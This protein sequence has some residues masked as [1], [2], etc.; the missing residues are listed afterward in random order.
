MEKQ[1]LLTALEKVKPGLANKEM[2]EQTT[3]FAFMNGYVVTYNDEISVSHP[4]PDLKIEGA[5]KAKELHSLLNKLK[6]DQLNLS[7]EGSEL[8]IACGKAKAGLT[9]QTKIN[10]PLDDLGDP[11]EWR[12]E[13]LPNSFLNAVRFSIFSCSN[14]VS[15]PVLGCLHISD[16]GIVEACDNYRLTRYNLKDKMPVSTFLLPATSAKEL[17][18]YNP[19]EIAETAGWIHFKTDE[20]TFFHAR[21]YQGNYPDT[22][23]LLAVE[24]RNLVLPDGLSDALDKAM[25]FS[26]QENFID[27][28]VNITLRDGYMTVHAKSDAGWFEEELEFQYVGEDITF[29]INPTFLKQIHEKIKECTLGKDKIKFEGDEK[30]HVVA[31]H[32]TND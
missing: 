11:D 23:T 1:D 7:I 15:M 21:V 18:K 9:L 20:G 28:H 29:S 12:W 14:D 22:S 8:L 2:I 5:V 17:I 3:S 26:K 19:V 25:I 30:T 31:L 4:L 10:L 32:A 16:Q 27:E 13:P 24:G 6:E